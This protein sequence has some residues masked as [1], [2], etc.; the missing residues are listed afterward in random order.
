MVRLAYDAM[1]HSIPSQNIN[2]LNSEQSRSDRSSGLGDRIEMNRETSFVD[3]DDDANKDEK[4]MKPLDKDFSPN[5][6]SVL[7]GRGKR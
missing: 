3:S 2:S 5:E 6:N 1:N 4:A 7:C